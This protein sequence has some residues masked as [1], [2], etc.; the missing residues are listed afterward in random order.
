MAENLPALIMSA[1]SLLPFAEGLP[2]PTNI[3]QVIDNA[4]VSD[5]HGIIPTAQT[6][7]TDI[8]SLPGSERSI[9][10]LIAVRLLCAVGDK[11]TY[12]ETVVTLACTEETA[13]PPRAR[14]SCNRAGR[15]WS[16]LLR[17]H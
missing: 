4:K 5:H 14:P 11:H 8:A 1:T 6:A 15:P 13:L 16:R 17:P 7:A 10:T 9:L 2:L 3:G 12:A